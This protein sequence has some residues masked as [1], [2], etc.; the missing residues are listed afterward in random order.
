MIDYQTLKNW[1]FGDITHR[2]DQR[3]VMLYAL[4]CGVGFDPMD[5]RQLPF[6]YEKHLRVM[7]S[8][9][10][11]IG[12]PGSW[13]RLPG[14]GVKWERVLHAEQDVRLFQALPVAATMLAKNRVTHLHDRGVDK[15][16]VAGLVRDIFDSQGTLVARASRIEVL[17]DDGG[18]LERSGVHDE[19]PQRLPALGPDCGQPDVEVVLPMVP[20][21]ALIYRLSGDP[22]PLHADPDIARSAGFSAPIFHGLGSFGF[23]AHA[24]LRGCC[25]YAPEALCRLALRFVSPVYP[26]ETLRFQIWRN[27]QRAARFRAFAVQRT[28]IVL[29]NGIA[30]FR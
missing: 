30:E 26:G 28:Q 29:D 4:G 12:T 21:A 24:I 5:P 3:D 27:G 8:M 18:F 9:A 25:D 11:V 10:S 14:T 19:A 7:P 17:R 23:A 22:N 2:Y 6:V 16:A 15:G 1:P 20:Q 13:W